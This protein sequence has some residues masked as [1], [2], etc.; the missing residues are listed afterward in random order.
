MKDYPIFA[1]SKPQDMDT[2][3]KIFSPILIREREREQYT[4]IQLPKHLPPG[5]KPALHD[6]KPATANT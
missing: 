4:G 5:K 1:K 2:S 3:I 6:E